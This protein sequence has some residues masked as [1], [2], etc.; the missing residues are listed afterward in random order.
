MMLVFGVTKIFYVFRARA[1]R[2]FAAVH[3]SLRS[4]VLR[5]GRVFFFGFYEG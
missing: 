1:M 2:A 5:P 3:R 4:M